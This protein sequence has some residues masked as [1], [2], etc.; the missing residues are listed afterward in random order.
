MVLTKRRL[1]K[2]EFPLARVVR[3]VEQK[4]E[5]YRASNPMFLKLF[6]IFKLWFKKA[7][8]IKKNI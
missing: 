3:A 1:Q 8:N 2:D 4:E 7:Y 5:V 6:F